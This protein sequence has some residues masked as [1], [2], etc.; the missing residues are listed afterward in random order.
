MDRML[1][2]VQLIGAEMLLKSKLLASAVV[3]VLSMGGVAAVLASDSEHGDAAEFS[4]LP[5]GHVTLAAAIAT[6]EQQTGGQAIDA[7]FGNENG[8]MQVEV[9]I[10][11]GTAAQ[12]VKLD[13]TSGKVLSV[14][15]ADAN[16]QHEHE[17]EGG[18]DSD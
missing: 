7:S 1:R 17:H 13:A 4:R 6:A 10:V 3:G 18:E 5:T 2:A 15:A 9:E 16:D 11:K 8:A 14:T 12:S